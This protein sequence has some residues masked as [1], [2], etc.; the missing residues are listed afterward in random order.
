[1]TKNDE[2]KSC[3]ICGSAINLGA[4]K[5]VECGSFQ[6]WRRHL[7]WS[8]TTLALVVAIITSATALFQALFGG[9]EI[10]SNLA[11]SVQAAKDNQFI[12]NVVNSGDRPATLISAQ[13]GI[14]EKEENMDEERRLLSG[15]LPLYPI[16]LNFVYRDGQSGFV[17]ANY[18][19]TY[20]LELDQSRWKRFEDY[21][22]YDLE[23][24]YSH[25]ELTLYHKAFNGDLKHSKH[26][27]TGSMLAT[28][29]EFIRLGKINSEI[30][31]MNKG[32]YQF[33]DWLSKI[34]KTRIKYG[35]DG[36]VFEINISDM[37]LTSDDLKDTSLV[38]SKPGIYSKVYAEYRGK[39]LKD[40]KMLSTARIVDLSHNKISIDV[41]RKIVVAYKKLR[42]I[43]MVDTEVTAQEVEKLKDLAPNLTIVSSFG[44]INTP[45]VK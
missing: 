1:M 16:D 17:P 13:L 3:V 18:S 39:G 36:N 32:Y 9:D 7:S 40:I 44:K 37:S 24:R 15:Y 45:Q 12:V 8:N 5:C 19:D 35:P 42:Q 20:S 14:I 43:N 26:R 23:E 27:V 21:Y 4:I 29:R 30:D 28:I 22:T 11:T 25:A 6:D 33:V 2:R 34:S 38:D 31:T 10:G 41:I